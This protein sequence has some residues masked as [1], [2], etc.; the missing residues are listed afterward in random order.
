MKG[1]A[2]GEQ[3]QDRILSITDRLI[4]KP[5]TW[6]GLSGIACAAV[7]FAATAPA[8]ATAAHPSQPGVRAGAP[9][10]VGRDGAPTYYME[11]G[12]GNKDLQIRDTATG[13]IVATVRPPE[14]FK[15][16]GG[17]CVAAD[18]WTFVMVARKGLLPPPTGPLR[19]L[20]GQFNP[21]TGRVTLRRFSVP[22]ADTVATEPEA[23]ALSPAGSELAIAQSTKTNDTLIRIYSLQTGHARVW[24]ATRQQWFASGGGLS[25][26]SAGTLAMDRTSGKTSHLGVWLLNTATAG[27]NLVSDSRHVVDQSQPG[28]FTFDDGVLTTDGNDIVGPA[29]AEIGAKK[30]ADVRYISEIRVI[31]A[32]TG[33]QVGVLLHHKSARL[34]SRDI[35][36]VN[37]SGDVYVVNVSNAVYQDGFGVLSGHTFTRIHLV[38]EKKC[39][40]TTSKL[41]CWYS[42]PIF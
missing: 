42:Y 16:F 40:T 8:Q 28:G 9:I 4:R 38:L 23:L 17:I 37:A 34:L 18:Y 32:A 29:Y 30:P 20:L 3:L 15:H 2:Q 13:A 36:W 19:Y 10:R 1:H 21:R 5:L 41:G 26:S 35:A 39:P 25:W 27:S 31:S 22:G 14:P 33:K 6:I 24:R 7:A 12:F 11:L